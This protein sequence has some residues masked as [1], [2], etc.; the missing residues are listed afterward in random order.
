MGCAVRSHRP[1]VHPCVLMLSNN[2]ECTIF[3]F[4]VVA[5]SVPVRARRLSIQL[6]QALLTCSGDATVRL[7]G[8]K[9]GACLRTFSGHGA[10]VL[11]ARFNASGTVVI[12]AGSDGLI[13]S[14]NTHSGQ[15][16]STLEAHDGKI[17]ALDVAEG[18]DECVLSG[19]DNGSLALWVSNSAAL[20]EQD[21]ALT[22]DKIQQQQVRSYPPR[23]S[24]LALHDPGHLP[25]LQ[26]KLLPPVCSPAQALLQLLESAGTPEGN[27]HEA[28]LESRKTCNQ[29]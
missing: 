3:V 29:S 14:W 11:R 21:R 15:C 20:Q 26:V 4:M 28:V 8:V 23:L 12:S 2:P 19:S 13:K 24:S 9:N 5:F 6:M 27:C 18:E 22:D 16:L 25:C 17:W 10:S 1:G 7:W